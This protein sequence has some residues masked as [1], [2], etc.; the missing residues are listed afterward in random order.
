MRSASL[1]SFIKDLPCTQRRTEASNFH[2]Y[3]ALDLKCR[4]FLFITRTN[5]PSPP[6]NEW[7]FRGGGGRCVLLT[8]GEIS[9]N[10]SWPD[11]RP[12]QPLEEHTNNSATKLRYKKRDSIQ[13]RGLAS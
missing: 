6:T 2:V 13:N 11:S 4:D 5:Y 8:W 9:C 1:W 12:T 3:M 7:T 10:T